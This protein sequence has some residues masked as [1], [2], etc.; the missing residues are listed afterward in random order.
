MMNK[1]PL[2]AAFDLI[3]QSRDTPTLSIS[4]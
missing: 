4:A 1:D 2:E 3:V